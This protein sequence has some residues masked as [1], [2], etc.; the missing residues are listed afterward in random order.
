MKEFAKFRQQNNQTVTRENAFLREEGGPLAVE[1]ALVT[2]S[3]SKLHRNALSSTAYGGA[4]SR[5]EPLVR[6][7]PI[8]LHPKLHSNSDLSC[9]RKGAS[10]ARKSGL[11]AA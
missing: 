9:R 11:S 5:R 1:G 6:S 2:L 3:L 10:G 4:P 8:D 7:N